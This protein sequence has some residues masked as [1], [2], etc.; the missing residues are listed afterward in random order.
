[1]GRDLC[2]VEELAWCNRSG[3]FIET[4]LCCSDFLSKVFCSG[5]LRFQVLMEAHGTEMNFPD[6]S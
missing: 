5:K 4:A 2:I 3:Y 6:E 1:M